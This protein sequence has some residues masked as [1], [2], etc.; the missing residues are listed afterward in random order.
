MMAV[1]APLAAAF[2]KKSTVSS[3]ELCELLPMDDATL[4]QHVRAGNIEFIRFG[5]GVSAPRRFTLEAVMAF[6]EE[7]REREAPDVGLPREVVRPLRT[8][9]GAA[10]GAVSGIL[11][12]LLEKRGT[13]KAKA[14]R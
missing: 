3:A 8:S 14:G 4:R 12:G 10:S 5:L 1:P 6:L 7:R 2:E 9:P 13:T 11:G